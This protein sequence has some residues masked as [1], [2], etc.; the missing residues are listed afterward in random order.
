MSPRHRLESGEHV[1]IE[2]TPVARGLLAPLVLL[3]VLEAVVVVIAHR[4]AGLHHVEAIVMAC[5]GVGPALVVLTRGWRWRSH[6]IVVTTRRVIVEGG[7]LTRFS[8]HI[9]LGDVLATHASQS[10]AER[11]R[12]RGR[13]GLETGTGTLWLEPVRH[14]AALRRLIDRARRDVRTA[15]SWSTWFD[16]VDESEGPPW[17]H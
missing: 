12:R 8:T 16:E 2:V 5:L 3:V 11:I 10:L 1:V 15:G 4:W 17:L 9:E 13:V 14:P 7:V 6:R